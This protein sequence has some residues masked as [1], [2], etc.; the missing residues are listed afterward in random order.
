MMCFIDKER[1]C[2]TKCMAYMGGRRHSPKCMWLELVGGLTG[3]VKA[4]AVKESRTRHPRS[5]KPP[6]VRS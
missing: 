6:E 5:A 4:S 3:L 1:L 2:D